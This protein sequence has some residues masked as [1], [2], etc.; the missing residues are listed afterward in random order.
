M[1]FKMPTTPSALCRRH[2]SSNGQED[3]AWLG[4]QSQSVGEFMVNG[5]IQFEPMNASSSH[6]T[7]R[8][9]FICSF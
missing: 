8:I 6:R 7:G 5:T 3:H 2:Y 9:A 1:R 4:E